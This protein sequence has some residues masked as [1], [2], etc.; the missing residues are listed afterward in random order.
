MKRCVLCSLA[1]L[2]LAVNAQ[3]VPKDK[4]K[5]KPTVVDNPKEKDNDKYNGIVASVPDSGSTALLLR[6]SLLALGVANRRFASRSDSSSRTKP[7]LVRRGGLLI[8]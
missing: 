2:A 8:S 1:A 5:D 4:D 3:A 6:I 7:A